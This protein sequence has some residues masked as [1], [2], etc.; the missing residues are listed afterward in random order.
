VWSERVNRRRP[1]HQ[2]LVR[3]VTLHVPLNI[4]VKP[5]P[6]SFFTAINLLGSLIALLS[7]IFAVSLV[8][9]TASAGSVACLLR[10]HQHSIRP[11]T[12]ADPCS[13][14]KF[15]SFALAFSLLIRILQHHARHTHCQ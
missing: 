4:V 7:G 11:A 5:S 10:Q 2:R 6:L 9:A 14:L 3:K 8:L 12:P 13:L 15:K 1:W